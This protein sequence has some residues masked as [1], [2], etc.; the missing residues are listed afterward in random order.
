[1]LAREIHSDG[2]CCT[3]GLGKRRFFSK[4]GQDAANELAREYC[5]RGE[6][7]FCLYLDAEDEAFA[8]TDAHVQAYPESPAWVSFREGLVAGSVTHRRAME[9]QRAVPRFG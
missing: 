3:V 4:F 5:R 1:M 9:L 7:F 6:Y 8:Y 2:A